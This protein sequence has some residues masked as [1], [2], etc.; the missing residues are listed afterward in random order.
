MGI[1]YPIDW[2]SRIRNYLIGFEELGLDTSPIEEH[3]IKLLG[4]PETGA[5]IRK[6]RRELAGQ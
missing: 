2:E 5:M 3:F 1:P 4:A 6:I